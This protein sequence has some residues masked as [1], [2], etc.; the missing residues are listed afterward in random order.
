MITASVVF[1]RYANGRRRIS[2][3]QPMSARDFADAVSR[4][5]TVL[6]GMKA[7]DP[8]SSFEIVSVEISGYQGEVCKGAHMF[9]TA[10]EMSARLN[11]SKA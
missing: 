8:Q 7:A 9:E 5:Q 4:A 1:T 10:D 6:I 3:P 11:A 2:E